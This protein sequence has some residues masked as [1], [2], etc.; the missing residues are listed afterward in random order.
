MS[1]EKIQVASPPCF[2]ST[3]ESVDEPSMDIPR[4]R[5]FFATKIGHLVAELGSAV[6]DWQRA[7]SVAPELMPATLE[8]LADKEKRVIQSLYPGC[9][10]SRRDQDLAESLVPT[11]PNAQT[12]PLD[13]DP[14]LR[15]HRDDGLD[16]D[17][18]LTQPSMPNLLASPHSS[19]D[20]PPVGER[21][22]DIVPSSQDAAPIAS[23]AIAGSLRSPSPS[24][25]LLSV[26]PCASF[27]LSTRQLVHPLSALTAVRGT[28]AETV[29]VLL[30]MNPRPN[31]A[32]R[33]DRRG[34][35][36]PLE[37]VSHI[38]AYYQEGTS[39]DL[40]VFALGP[41]SEDAAESATELFTVVKDSPTMIPLAPD[42]SIVDNDAAESIVFGFPPG[43]IIMSRESDQ[44]TQSV[45][46]SVTA[47]A[48][49]GT[50]DS[51]LP[52]NLD[53]KGFIERAPSPLQSKKLEVGSTPWWRSQICRGDHGRSSSTPGYWQGKEP[54]VRRNRVLRHFATCKHG[55]VAPE[56][57]AFAIAC[58]KAAGPAKKAAD[59]A[60]LQFM[61]LPP[62]AAMADDWAT[63][64]GDQHV[65]SA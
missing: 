49:A 14:A 57:T 55:I 56:L 4:R 17:Q 48:A 34:L 20:E 54:N 46:T 31:F 42:G 7:C 39:R 6:D 38:P 9:W 5:E 27:A 53:G 51:R 41:N 18:A 43:S 16:L 64:V 32:S 59:R 61:S 28:N 44:E 24:F 62:M 47:T 60:A 15:D 23:T 13:S 29:Y 50:L 37:L 25:P 21:E 11:A 3:V 8:H 63:P 33:R 12:T 26:P 19:L 45:C 1:L 35:V 52:S 65:L 22:T 30:M 36:R 58:L 40:L 2:P 10:P